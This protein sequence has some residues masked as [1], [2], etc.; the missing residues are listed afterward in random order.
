MLGNFS[1]DY[2]TSLISLNYSHLYTY[3]YEL[4]DILFPINNF[5]VQNLVFLAATCN[6][7]F[8]TTSS[9]P[10]QLKHTSLLS[11]FTHHTFFY[12]TVHLWNIFLQLTLSHHLLYQVFFYKIFWSNFPLCFDPTFPCTFHIPCPCNSCNLAKCLMSGN[13]H[14]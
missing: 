2:G 10:S 9:I 8:S 11:N 1:S 13:Y 6:L 7:L 5:N 14:M 3:I 12:K 4:S